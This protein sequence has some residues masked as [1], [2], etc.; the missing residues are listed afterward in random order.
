[1]PLDFDPKEVVRAALKSGL[2]KW[3][4]ASPAPSRPL[5]KLNKTPAAVLKV[6]KHHRMTKF[7]EARKAA[8]LNTATG[9][10]LVRTKHPE[11]PKRNRKL[12]MRFYERKLRAKARA[13]AI[14]EL[15]P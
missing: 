7:R 5:P 4:T 6:R 8:G 2:L 3:G 15:Q 9:K 14:F 1:M 10:P 12:Y 13:A 11:L